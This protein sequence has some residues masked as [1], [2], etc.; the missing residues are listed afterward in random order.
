MERWDV[1]R[2]SWTSCRRLSGL[3]LERKASNYTGDRIAIMLPN[4]PQFAVTMAGRFARG[5][6]LAVNVNPL[7]TARELE[8]QL[9][10]L[11]RQP[12]SFWKTRG[13]LGR[14][15]RAH[16]HS[17]HGAGF[18][19]R[20]VGPRLWPLDHVFGQAFGQDGAGV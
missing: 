14:G 18:H 4:V 9:K 15:D 19:G 3:G 2:K 5:L 16:G 13:H 8:H 11:A 7:Y 1:L 6:Y 17:A 10:T 12:L 20:F